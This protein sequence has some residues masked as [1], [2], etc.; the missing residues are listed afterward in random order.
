MG[1]YSPHCPRGE[2]LGFAHHRAEEGGGIHILSNPGKVLKSIGPAGISSRAKTT[3]ALEGPMLIQEKRGGSDTLLKLYIAIDDDLKALQPPLQ[4][5]QFPRN[6][7]G[8]T[9]TLSVAEVLTI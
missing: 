3:H 4:A 1:A 5:R 6:P 7:R 9:P 8:G 2:Q